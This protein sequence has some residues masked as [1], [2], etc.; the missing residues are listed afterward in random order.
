MPLMLEQGSELCLA[1]LRRGRVTCGLEIT[2]LPFSP[3][4]AFLSG[5][6]DFCQDRR[7]Y[8]TELN[9]FGSRALRIA[10]LPREIERRARTEFV[11]DLTVPA[12]QWKIGE[13]H[14][15]HIRRAE[16]SGV[17]VRRVRTEALKDHLSMCAHSLSRRKERGEI[18]PNVGDSSEFSGA[19]LQGAG[20]IFQVT[21][22]DAVLSSIL[23]L[24]SR[25]GAYYHSAG[26]SRE[27]MELGASHFLVHSVARTLQE[28]RAEIF[29]LGGA[30][31]DSPGLWAF[32]SRFGAVAVETEAVRAVL[33]GALHRRFVE[34]LHAM[35]NIGFRR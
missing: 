10:A 34:A 8:E 15:R 25:T 5:L 33:C 2:S 20:E 23:V 21:R 31:I 16:K 9:T 27:G 1:F 14:R 28:E 32:K 30:A 13:T 35:K 26:T 11:I 17:S 6:V 7:I 18:V 19:L 4:G 22:G 12:S 24:R 29:N 3:S